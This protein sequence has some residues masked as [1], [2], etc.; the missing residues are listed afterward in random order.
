MRPEQRVQPY[1]RL[2]VKGLA[3]CKITGELT[4]FCA[5]E[6]K[7]NYIYNL[8]ENPK[9]ERKPKFLN[10]TVAPVKI[11]LEEDCGFFQTDIKI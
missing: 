10:S 5:L 1:V 9:Q 3:D 2:C 11:K 6:K 7:A 4:I 8:M